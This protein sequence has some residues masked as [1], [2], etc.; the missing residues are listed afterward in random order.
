MTPII[1][2][3]KHDFL[4]SVSGNWLQEPFEEG[5]FT[6]HG[7]EEDWQTFLQFPPKR[8]V[9]PRAHYG[10]RCGFHDSDRGEGLPWRALH[11]SDT[12]PRSTPRNTGQVPKRDKA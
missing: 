2:R 11:T 1:A 3:S 9:E 8:G 5:V 10:G 6:G 7:L 12:K 4:P